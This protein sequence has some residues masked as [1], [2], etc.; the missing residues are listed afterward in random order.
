MRS[1]MAIHKF[2][3]QLLKEEEKIK[4]IC[5]EI[6]DEVKEGFKSHDSNCNICK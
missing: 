4:V 6:K 2:K 5:A 3:K 1:D